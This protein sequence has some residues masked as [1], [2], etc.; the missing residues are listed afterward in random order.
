MKKIK[1]NAWDSLEKQ[2]IRFDEWLEEE[3]IE[4][5]GEHVTHNEALAKFLDFHY[6]CDLLQY[7]GLKD[8]NGKEIFFGDIVLWENSD[9]ERIADKV[10]F[11]NGAFRMR[12][13]SFTLYDYIDSNLFEVIGNIYEKPE[14]LE[15]S[16]C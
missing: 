10:I 13:M 7:A 14:L 1:F 9:G 8:K 15:C 4:V 3:D 5:D 2:Y 6:G 11:F 16:K 12:N